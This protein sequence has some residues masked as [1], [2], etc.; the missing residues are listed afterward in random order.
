M[1]SHGISAI[2]NVF[3]YYRSHD[4]LMENLENFSSM[5]NISKI[6]YLIW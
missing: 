1:F 3:A 2:P 5:A 4:K 6:L